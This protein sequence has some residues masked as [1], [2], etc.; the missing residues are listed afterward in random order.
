MTPYENYLHSRLIALENSHAQLSERLAS[1]ANTPASS[2]STRGK[3]SRKRKRENALHILSSGVQGL[4]DDQKVVRQYLSVSKFR[5][6]SLFK[7][8]ITIWSVYRNVHEPNSVCS[9][10]PVKTRSASVTGT[11]AVTQTTTRPTFSAQIGR[12]HV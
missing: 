12:A 2:D 7:Q 11:T 5:T 4:N 9:Q 3:G 8:L 1:H 10:E 6:P